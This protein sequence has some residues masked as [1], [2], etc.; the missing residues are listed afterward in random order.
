MP[1][2][3]A[4][5]AAVAAA[6]GLTALLGAGTASAHVTANPDTATQGSS[7]TF[8]LRVPNERPQ[9]GTTKVTLRL[10]ADQ[11]I[12]TVSTS[13]VPGW[14]ISVNSEKL[15]EP[16]DY[17]GQRLTETVRSVTWTATPG[18]RI[19]PDQFQEFDLRIGDLPTDADTFVM[20]AE[21]TYDSGEV[22]RW[23]QPT[24]AGGQ[25][26]AKPAPTLT[27]TPGDGSGHH[28]SGSGAGQHGDAEAASAGSDSTARWLGGAGL[29][30]GALGLGLGG[31][32]V[33][34]S[35]KAGR[36]GTGAQ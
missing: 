32:A 10:P 33:L 22:V 20:A 34:R 27:L 36:N 12:S 23:D 15:P 11:P 18:N 7:A 14:D 26:P 30:V 31:G 16:V 25:E 17:Q 29:V 8:A 35:R 21:Q 13:P 24:P 5:T 1:R 6:A 19:G 3:L 4:R 2:S 28:G 9:A